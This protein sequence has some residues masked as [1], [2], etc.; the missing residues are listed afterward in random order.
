MD[1]YSWDTLQH[2]KT[3]AEAKHDMSPH[4]SRGVRQSNLLG[5]GDTETMYLAKIAT[6]A[7]YI[8]ATL[9]HTLQARTRHS[10]LGLH[11]PIS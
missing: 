3:T 5:N 4:Y 6:L 7:I 10:C 2:K 11:T 1:T 8:R 9:A